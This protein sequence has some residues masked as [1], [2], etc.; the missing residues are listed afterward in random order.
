ML[1][2]VIQSDNYPVDNPRDEQAKCS[3]LL[4]NTRLNNCVYHGNEYFD[5]RVEIITQHRT[6][7]I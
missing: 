3:Y 7:F 2:F 6:A 1:E 5:E 4:Y